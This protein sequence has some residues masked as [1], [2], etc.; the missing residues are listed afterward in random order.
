MLGS[1]TNEE[2][3]ERVH[4]MFLR[5][6]AG[7]RRLKMLV[8][9]QAMSSQMRMMLAMKEKKALVGRTCLL[10]YGIESK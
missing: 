6:A 10:I 4:H 7:R 9:M 3:R 1:Q 8:L 5:R 2:I